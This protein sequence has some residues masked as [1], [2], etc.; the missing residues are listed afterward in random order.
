MIRSGIG[1]SVHRTGG[2]RRVV[3]I[4]MLQSR[5]LFSEN[6]RKSIGYENRAFW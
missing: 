6:K 3:W 5:Y 2:E 1:W 4:A